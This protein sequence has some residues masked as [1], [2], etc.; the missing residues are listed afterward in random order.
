[1]AGKF[2]PFR[3]DLELIRTELLSITQ[4]Q[5]LSGYLAVDPAPVGIH[6]RLGDFVQQSSYE[7]MV[8]IDNSALPLSWYT[9]A[10][11]AVR[12][13]TGTAV[14]AAVFSDGDDEELAE[15]LSMDY[16]ERAEFGSSIADMLAMSRSRLLIA[17]GST[18]SEWASYLGQVP[19]IWHP[20]KLDQS[21]MLGRPDLE[22]EWARG[23]SL[24]DW[25]PAVVR[26]K[27]VRWPEE[28]VSKKGNIPKPVQ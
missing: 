2:E 27:P 3:N 17:S 9:A 6:V 10:L 25:I 7:D 13:L 11:E 24:P 21:V 16:V 23:E 15:L 5:H 4:P 28:S 8:E 19:T 22:I 26:A 1:M 14:K 12:A 18:F 20:G